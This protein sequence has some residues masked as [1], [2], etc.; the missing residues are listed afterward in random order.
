LL[1]D[2]YN[3]NKSI[4]ENYNIIDHIIYLPIQNISTNITKNIL[5]NR[6]LELIK[7]INNKEVNKNDF[8]FSKNDIIFLQK[9][10]YMY[11]IIDYT[12]KFS[13]DNI[14]KIDF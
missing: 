2:E 1:R 7:K 4:D 12:N 10:E 11:Y 9:K 5:V 3:K 14:Q 6:I 13:K 8:A